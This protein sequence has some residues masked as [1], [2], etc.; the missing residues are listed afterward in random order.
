VK[1]KMVTLPF[2]LQNRLLMSFLQSRPGVIISNWTC[3][4]MP[5]MNRYERLYRVTIEIIVIAILS[6]AV[7]N[8]MDYYKALFASILVVHTLFWS[9]NGHFYV[10]MRYLKERKHDPMRFIAY[11]EGINERLQGKSFLRG[12]VAF[13]SLSKDKFSGSSDFDMRFLRKQGLI[14]SLRAFN[15]CA[16]ERA[17]AFFQH[18][19]LDIYVFDLEEIP[20]K[21]KGDEPPIIIWDPEGIFHRHQ[22][23]IEFGEFSSRFRC[24]FDQVDRAKL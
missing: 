24:K 23:H 15:Y 13:G 5:Y 2:N 17:R 8:L 6:W 18:F 21:I 7:A 19:P 10:L 9:F 12:A 14:N 1:K 3:Q 4:G 16:L 22:D 20:R 11:I